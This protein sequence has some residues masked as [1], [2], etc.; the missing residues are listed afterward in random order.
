MPEKLVQ[1]RVLMSVCEHHPEKG[2]VCYALSYPFTFN[3]A[4]RASSKRPKQRDDCTVRTLAIALRFK[5]DEA[6]DLLAGAGRKCSRGFRLS[7]W[8][9][10]QPFARKMPFP[11]VKGERRMNP[12]RFCR[13]YPTGTFICKVAKHVFAVVDGVVHDT[14]ENPPDRCIYT[15][16]EIKMDTSKERPCASTS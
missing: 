7:D 13:D 8:L 12:H 11:A 15:A 16:W 6:Y 5:Y 9:N 1:R 4:G 10:T 3:D 14:F 2:N